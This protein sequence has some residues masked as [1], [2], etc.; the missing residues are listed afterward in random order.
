MPSLLTLPEDELH[1]LT[2]GFTEQVLMSDALHHVLT[3]SD[4]EKNLFSS[5]RPV[6]LQ[7]LKSRVQQVLV[8]KS[9]KNQKQFIF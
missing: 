1:E 9:K 2:E 8:K 5:D 7:E 4:R 6:S 3:L